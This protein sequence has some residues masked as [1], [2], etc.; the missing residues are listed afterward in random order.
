MSYDGMLIQ[1]FRIG[2][3]KLHSWP[4]YRAMTECLPAIYPSPPWIQSSAPTKR[5]SCLLY[6]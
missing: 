4:R 6:N 3:K 1:E 5:K 2:E